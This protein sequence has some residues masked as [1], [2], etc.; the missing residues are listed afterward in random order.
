MQKLAEI[1][2]ERPVFATMLV[3][4]LTFI[5]AYAYE[6]LGVDQFPK[7]DFP[8]V[9]VTTTL[10]GASPEEVETEISKKIE[11]AVNT[12]SGIDEL[13]SISGE[14]VS[15]V[16]VT[17]VLERQVS[18]AAQDVRDKVNSILKDLPKEIDPP[19]IE[20]LDPDAQPIMTVAIS[21]RRQAREITEI[22]DKKIKQQIESISGVGQVK[23]IGDRK[24]EI[25]V[26][27]DAQ[28]LDSYRLTTSQ[29]EAATSQQNIE[30][31]G[32]RVDQGSREQVLRTLGRV[33]SVDELSNIIVTTIGATPIKL[34]DVA[35]IEDGVE[36]PRTMARLDGN[37]AIL[38]EIRKQSGTNTVEVV[39]SVKEKLKEIQQFLPS[40]FQIQI[41]RDQSDFIKGSFEA[42]R[43]HLVLGGLFAAL[44]VLLFM[45]NLRS[46][47][48]AAIAIPTSIISTYALMYYMKFTLNQMTMLALV[49]SV[50]IVID[51]AIV[52]LENIYRFI[53]EKGVDAMTAAREATK[54]IGLAVMATTL[55]LIVIFLPVAFMDGIVGRFLN[56]FGLT[57][58]FAIGVSL[59]VSFTLTPMMCSRFIKVK[60]DGKKH[61]SKESL[62]YS[63]LE[64]SYMWLL[65]LSLRYRAAVV[66]V[67]IL[68]VATVVPLF[69]V[70]GKDF[71]PKD[72]TSDFEISVRAPEGYSLNATAD[73][74]TKIEQDL[75]TLPA[76]KHLLVTI[77]ADGQKSVN[78]ANIYVRLQ[79]LS[80]R[81]G[82]KGQNQAEIMEQARNLLNKYKKDL[83]ISITY[84][85]AISGGGRSNTDLQYSIQGPDLKNLTDY[86]SQIAAAARSIGVVDVDSSLI[87]GKPEMKI[88]IDRDKAADLG[89]R[90]GDIASTIRT[91][92][93]GNNRVS[94]YREGEDRYQ[95]NIRAELSDRS[96][97]QSLEQL[98]VP[99][100]KLGLVRLDQVV[101]I[102]TGTGPS[103]I[104]RYNRQRQVTINGNLESKGSL[105]EVLDK[106]NVAVSQMKIP[107]EY[108]HGAQGRGKELGRAARNFLIAFI[109]SF[110]FMYMILAAQFESFADPV[111][112]LL[113][114]PLSVPFAILSLII[115]Q[116]SVNIFSSLGILML[117]GVVKKN[118]ILQIDHAN[119]L[120]H[121]GLKL[122]DAVLQSSRDRLRP[123]LMTTLA[124]VAGML[125]MALGQG[126][127]SGSRR[128]IAIVVIGGQ[129]LCL[130]LTLIVTPVAYSI[131]HSFIESGYSRR[132]SNFFKTK[133]SGISKAVIILTFATFTTAA[134]A[135]TPTQ[136]PYSSRSE[137]RVGVDE[138][139]QLPI[140]LTTA[141]TMALE[142]N[143]EIE[144]EKLNVQQA[145]SDLTSVHGSYDPTLTFGQF[146]NRQL[147]PVTNALGGGSGSINTKTLSQEFGIKG[148]ISSGATYNF[149]ATASRVDTNNFF[150]NLNPLINSGINFNF[151]QPL[152]KNRKVD[153]ARRRIQV[154]QKQLDI[155][156]LQFRQRVIEIITQVQRAYWDLVFARRSVDIARE[157]VKLAETQL[158]RAKRLIEAGSQAPADLIQVEAQL[159]RR[160]EDVLVSLES[161]TRTENALK[162]LILPDRSHL[163][164]RKVLLPTDVPQGKPFDFDLDPLVK[165]ALE[166]RIELKQASIQKQLAEYDMEFYRNQRKPQIDLIANYNLTGVA[167]TLVNRPNP[168]TASNAQ[169]LQR[170]N[171]I[172]KLLNFSPLPAPTQG[173]IPDFLTGGIGQSFANLFGNRF[174]T[175]RVGIQ[176]EI[177]LKNRA[178]SGQF[179]RAELENRKATVQRQRLEAIIEA[180][181]RNALQAARTAQERIQAA[182]AARIAAQ[183]QLESE[184]RRYEAGLS[185]NFLVLTRQQ[186]LSEAKGRELRAETDYDKALAELQKATGTTL[187]VNKIEV[188]S[189]KPSVD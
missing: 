16:F 177:P 153:Q 103:Q 52:V 165:T 45:R 79:S 2:I 65:K 72:D 44:V 141:V 71:L 113:S 37:E 18:E 163:E 101:K 57:A 42:I 93:G 62:F 166:N 188:V 41:I 92:V 64:K 154:A 162:I 80:E 83:R 105:G 112:I 135:Q 30:L 152:L 76:V 81:N 34:S 46:T 170:V 59:F 12:I 20:K 47:L 106:L 181:V 189:P 144:I 21:A 56:S 159:Q 98:S 7:V 118:S 11:E 22:A 26:K 114:L 49:L 40:D 14:G 133:L 134:F 155:S 54:E 158:E 66:L 140:S 128:S 185:T 145:G 147:S 91:L 69:K 129:S 15:Q 131:F 132:F 180:E 146:F 97:L 33:K 6:S 19:L 122:Y 161:V 84:L 160:H 32:G 17:F 183:Q 1:C 94:N 63:I 142:N 121:A 38:L 186:E 104:E 89:V 39:D 50:G 35:Y 100:S 73:L 172:S 88:Y 87:T 107:A 126:P 178:I 157:S 148:L 27:L 156:D 3:L 61:S 102:E 110:V 124:L 23:F 58:A 55:S 24:R 119:E 117:F 127:G 111:I 151:Q 136:K 176:I 171:D 143:R 48:I 70:V 138:A 78:L 68:V 85:A 95:I 9:T 96:S 25:Q 182:T 187:S 82:I 164:W 86:S 150:A 53:E 137:F 123:I 60:I 90:V 120:R 77:G 8:I 31:P 139:D 116:Q 75:R 125:P 184:Q 169:L 173:S 5:G 179:G 4:V 115:F 174:N 13:R 10:P 149:T 168:F 67:S 29:V 51:D 36:E 130:L 99:S 108:K 43:E 28:K 74:M 175:F 167:G 109:L